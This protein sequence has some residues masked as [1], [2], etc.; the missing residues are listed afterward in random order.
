[1]ARSTRAFQSQI[2][3]SQTNRSHEP[4][5]AYQAYQAAAKIGLMRSLRRTAQ[6]LTKTCLMRSGIFPS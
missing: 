3:V 2:T 1:M 5:Q 6:P 4:R